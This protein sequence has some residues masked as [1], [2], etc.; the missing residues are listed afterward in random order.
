MCFWSCWHGGVE[1]GRNLGAL[2]SCTAVHVKG[3]PPPKDFANK[4]L[5]I[6]GYTGWSTGKFGVA[7]GQH[8]ATLGPKW[9]KYDT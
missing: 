4:N 3:A 9:P 7:T 2:T 5:K 6:I 8:L 1:R